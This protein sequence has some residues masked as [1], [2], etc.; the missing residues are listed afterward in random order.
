MKHFQ[1][2][3]KILLL[4]SVIIMS[5][6][7]ME[8]NRR[9]NF[10]IIFTD[11]LG[12]G[13][14]SCFGH[15]TINT[16]NLDKMASQGMKLTQ[17]YVGSS[18]CTPSRAALLTGK[19]PV[20]TGMYGNR[21]V[22]FPDNAGGL[23]PDEKTIA[24]ALKDLDYKTACVGKWHLGHLEKY[25]PTNHGFDEFY[26]IP[27]SNDMRPENKKWDYAQDNFPPLPFLDGTDTIGVSL[28]Q[29][30]F[31]KMFTERSIS[32]IQHNKDHPFFLYLAHTAPHT[33]LLVEEENKDKSKR[34]IYGDVVEELDRSVGQILNTLK[35]LNLEKNT[36]VIF[37]SDNGPWGWANINGG[38]AGLLKGNKGSVYEGGYRVPAIAWMPQSITKGTVSNAICSTLD[39]YPTILA[40]AGSENYQK[41]KLDGVN[42]VNTFF[43]NQSV[44]SDIHYYRQDTL[45]ALRHEH[46]KIYV[47]DPNPWNDEFLDSDLPLLYN[48]EHD[49]SEK[50]NIA[51]LNPDIINKLSQLVNEHNQSVET[52]PSQYDEILPSYKKAYEAYN[53]KN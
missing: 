27:Y 29:S 2:N 21:S 9:P 50:Y 40:M 17:F 37:T 26:G 6:S 30:N 5:C 3:L 52:V 10:I 33:P 8:N 34:G 20:R 38:S 23:Q 18:I 43:E 15:P 36:F 14:L 53:R 4:A 12:Y 31:I 45:V 49:P 7:S 22:L 48:I 42:I 44:R 13:D 32:F 39:L 25:M 16:P 11:D 41:E 46:W 47:K 19:L 24:T 1:N 51:K 35:D 28:D